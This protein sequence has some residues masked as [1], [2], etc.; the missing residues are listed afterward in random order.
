MTRSGVNLG[1]VSV[2]QTENFKKL[3]V[4]GGLEWPLTLFI[5][6]VAEWFNAAV[7]KAVE[8]KSSVGSNPTLSGLSIC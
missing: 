4:V 6:K 1:K 2:V 3:L 7:L 5:G 8:R